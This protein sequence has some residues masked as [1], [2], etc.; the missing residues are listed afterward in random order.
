[1]RVGGSWSEDWIIWKM[2]TY[3]ERTIKIIIKRHLSG[4]SFM[5]QQNKAVVLKQNL[6]E[7]PFSLYKRLILSYYTHYST[8]YSILT[9]LLRVIC[10]FNCL[11]IYVLL[12]SCLISHSMCFHTT[13]LKTVIKKL[14]LSQTMTLKQKKINKKKAENYHKFI[15]K[16]LLNIKCN[17]TRS[18]RTNNKIPTA[19]IC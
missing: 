5:Y 15:S 9:K 7:L 16:I 4:K 19:N 13:W 8:V 10:V 1:M 11:N 12:L 17:I 2:M 3:E 14:A 18:K 6:V